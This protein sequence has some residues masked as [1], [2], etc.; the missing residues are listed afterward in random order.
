MTVTSCSTM[1]IM[2]DPAPTVTAFTAVP[3]VGGTSLI[4]DTVAQV[5]GVGRAC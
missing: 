2:P 4:L 5:G 1:V 3:A